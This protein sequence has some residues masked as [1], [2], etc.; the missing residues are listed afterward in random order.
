LIGDALIKLP[1]VRALRAAFP[2]AEIHWITT[3]GPTAYSGPLRDITR[4]LIDAIHETPSAPPGPFDL[5]LDTRGRWREA[6]RARR[7]AKGG[8]FIAPA[9][10]YLFSSKK[11][12]FFAKRPRRMIARLMQMLEL[13]AG[14]APSSSGRLSIPE[15]FAEKAARLL[16]EGPLY[17]GL[18]PGAGN[19]IKA[20]PLERFVAVAQRQTEKGRV[21]VFL[22]GPDEAAWKDG[23][24]T[25]VPQALFPLQERSVWGTDRIA[26]EETL[27]LAERLTLAIANDSGTSHMLAAAD[28][29]LLSLFGPTSAEKLAPFVSRGKVLRA[30]AFG[31]DEMPRIPTES[32][33]QAI[34]EVLFLPKNT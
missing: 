12:A 33:L 28:S 14:S 2:L 19:M 24:K 3:Q 11:P 13:A 26:L 25:L 17:I 16:P 22:L 18:A 5:L 8:V 27:A 32:V 23:L 30:Q 29:P 1:F 4:G 31:G 21:P 34:D 10:R 20:W 7:L 9:W 15:A 6:L